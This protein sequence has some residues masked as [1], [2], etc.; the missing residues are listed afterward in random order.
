MATI[1]SHFE[2]GRHR[3]GESTFYLCAKLCEFVNG[4]D[5]II[6]FISLKAKGRG[7]YPLAQG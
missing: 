4:L 7:L 5:W 3:P 1:I 2:T 6:E